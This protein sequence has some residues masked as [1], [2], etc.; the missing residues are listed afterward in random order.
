MVRKLAILGLL[1]SLTGCMGALETV[2]RLP[3]AAG[4]VIVKSTARVAEVAVMTPVRFVGNTAYTAVSTPVEI[5]T[6]SGRDVA[7][8]KV[9]LMTLQVNLTPR[10][11]GGVRSN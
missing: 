9:K 3:L 1:L 8:R 2:A 7:S 10:G 4:K 11:Q 5:I 6:D